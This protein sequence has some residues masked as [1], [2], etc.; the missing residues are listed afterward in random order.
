[1]RGVSST[2]KRSPCSLQLER[3]PAKQQRPSTAK[4]QK[5][6]FLKEGSSTPF[7]TMLFSMRYYEALLKNRSS[8]PVFSPG[9]YDEASLIPDI[10]RLNI[11]RCW[12]SVLEDVFE[13]SLMRDNSFSFSASSHLSEQLHFIYSEARNVIEGA[14]PQLV[15]FLLST[16][17]LRYEDLLQNVNQSKCS[18]SFYHVL[19]LPRCFSKH[20]IHFTSN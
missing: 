20:N 10:S 8:E 15:V 5:I 3:A 9:K 11:L 16:S 4:K 7:V 1:M 18:T 17:S 2:T 19:P 12:G 13:K 14:N 6:I